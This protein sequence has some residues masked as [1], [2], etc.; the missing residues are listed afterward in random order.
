MS[1]QPRQY[2]DRQITSTSKFLSLLLRHQPEVIGLELDSNGWAEVDEL[3]RL[4]NADRPDQLD[5]ELIEIVVSTNTKQRFVLS[6]DGERIR[7]NQGHSIEVDLGLTPVAPPSKLFHG[8]ASRFLESIM[9]DGLTKQ[10]RQHVH[11]SADLST[12][13][14]VGTRHGSPRVLVVDA[15]AMHA[16]GYEF[17]QSANGVWLTDAVPP[18]FLRSDG[19]EVIPVRQVRA[20]FDEETIRVYQAYGHDIA[21]PALAAGT[22]VAPFKMSRMTWIKPSFLWMMYR[23]GYGKKDN[24][25]ARVLALDIKRS[26]FEWALANS[27]LSHPRDATKAEAREL[28]QSNPVRIQWDPERNLQLEPLAHR[29]IQVGL[30]GEAVDR[31]VNDWI[32][33]V[34][35]VTALAHEVAGLLDAGREDDAALLL[36]TEA[37]YPLPA[38]LAARIDAS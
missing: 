6:E 37:A 14:N 10:S 21:E 8:T 9:A 2:N 1:N 26:G 24:G 30:R 25:Q 38:S 33:E 15:A 22:F 27:C 35:D 16:A 12:A 23:S 28:M 13:T 7:A 3:I 31:Y 4:A 36:P 20:V 18:Q 17:F 34:T 29:A 19:P 11:L 5:R 32:V